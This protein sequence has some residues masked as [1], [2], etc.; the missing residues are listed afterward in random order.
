MSLPPERIEVDVTAPP[1]S[2]PGRVLNELCTHA[3]ETRP[4]ECCGLLTGVGGNPFRSFQLPEAVLRFKQGVGRLIR[5]KRDHG[6]IVVLDPRIVRKNYGRLF[7]NAL[8]ECE[9]V[10]QQS[11]S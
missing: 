7:L 5:S 11:P 3:L 1:V 6:V 4:E 9:V 10:Q 8:P 2:I